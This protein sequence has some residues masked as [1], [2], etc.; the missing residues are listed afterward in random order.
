MGHTSSAVHH[1][2][3]LGLHAVVPG[4]SV[5]PPENASQNRSKGLTDRPQRAVRLVPLGSVCPEPSEAHSTAAEKAFRVAATLVPPGSAC[6]ET[7]GT[8][9]MHTAAIDKALGTWL[10]P[11]GSTCQVT[12]NQ[13]PREQLGE[14]TFSSALL[15]ENQMPVVSRSATLICSMVFQTL[16]VAALVIVPLLFTASTDLRQY[17]VTLLVAPTPPRGLPAAMPKPPRAVAAQPT[18]TKSFIRQGKMTFPMAVP[19][20]AAVISEA[21]PAPEIN[22]GAIGGGVYG[23]LPADLAGLTGGMAEPPPPPPAAVASAPNIPKPKGPLRV[24]GDVRAPHSISRVDPQYPLL[25]KQARIEGD[26]LIS[27]IIDPH[28]NVVEMKAL[29]GPPI[30]YTAAMA[31]LQ[32]WKFEPTYLNGEPWPI[33]YEVTLHFRLGAARPATD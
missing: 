12:S 4:G 33:E 5:C 9:A 13:P 18:P 31:A 25:A 3:N 29:S 15:S 26:V 10:V 20:H 23:G 27:A 8:A 14:P 17:A 6:P 16:L 7:P 11:A 30:L 32:Q 28:G 24:G 22:S 21:Q 1:S 19:K 2:W